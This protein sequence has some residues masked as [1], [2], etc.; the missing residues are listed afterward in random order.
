M[1][2]WLN[3]QPLLRSQAF[4]FKPMDFSLLL[5][6]WP[7]LAG[8][9]YDHTWLGMGSAGHINRAEIAGELHIKI[10]EKK[11]DEK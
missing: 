11:R 7:Q 1:V 8:V 4:L 10:G 6:L 2:P 3:M 9:G 5:Q